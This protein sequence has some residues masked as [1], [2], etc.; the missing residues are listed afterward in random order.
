[1]SD[2]R[3][4]RRHAQKRTESKVHA[5]VAEQQHI[6]DATPVAEER[7]EVA[8]TP[9]ESETEQRFR[10]AR[11]LERAGSNA[12]AAQVY[13]QLLKAEPDNIRARN[14]LGCLYDRQGMHVRALEQFEAAVSLSPDNIEILLN[15]GDTL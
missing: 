11:E 3:R 2:R 12:E 4:K 5:T 13:L 10:V 9:S 6:P 7:V 15:L 14:N 8:L 1:M